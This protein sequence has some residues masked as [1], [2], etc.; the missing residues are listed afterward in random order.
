MNKYN[1]D[2]NL[3]ALIEELYDNAT[4]SVYFDWDFG[5]WFRTTVGV[6]QGC[7]LSPTLFNL[8]LE[9]MT[10]ALEDHQFTISIGGRCVNNLRFAEDIDGIAG[11]QEKLAELITVTYFTVT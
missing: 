3:T 6:R 9:R 5:E 4:S 7:L 8:F 1:I 2:K 10:V 11:S